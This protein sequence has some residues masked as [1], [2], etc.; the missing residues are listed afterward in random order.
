MGLLSLALRGKNVDAAPEE[1]RK[2]EK[3]WGPLEPL[4]AVTRTPYMRLLVSIAFFAVL[5]KYFVDFAF[6]AEM[7]GRFTEVK[8]LASAFA[9]FSGTSQ[10]L[11]LLTRF[12]IAGRVLNRYGV[13][14]GLLV[15]PV[16]HLTCTLL[17]VVAGV[18]PGLAALGL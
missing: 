6:L 9:I 18:T 2:D 16:A 11:S 15:L 3:T 13:K 8:E 14:T 5:G 12:F 1:K 4:R 10:S 7:R 17:L